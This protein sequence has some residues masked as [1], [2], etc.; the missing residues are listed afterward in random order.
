MHINQWN[1][2]KPKAASDFLKTGGPVGAR[3]TR[4][5]TKLNE[6]G[7][8]TYF[9]GCLTLTWNPDIRRLSPKPRKEVVV[10]D[11]SSGRLRVNTLVPEAV[12]ADSLEYSNHLGSVI[13]PSFHWPFQFAYGSLLAIAQARLVITSR[14]HVALPAVGLGTPVIFTLEEGKSESGLPGGS[15]GRTEG[16]TELFHLAYHN[17]KNNSWVFDQNFDWENPPPNPAPYLRQRLV[18]NLWSRIKKESMF[19]DG[20][21]MFGLFPRATNPQKEGEEE[22]LVM[23]SDGVEPLLTLRTIESVFFHHPKASVTFLR[24]SIGSTWGSLDDELETLQESGYNL[25]VVEEMPIPWLDMW[26]IHSPTILLKPVPS[27]NSA[28]LR[29]CNFL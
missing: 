21:R 7:V 20:A 10:V 22:L 14:I 26:A 4:T 12:L 29:H 15:G 11:T 2:V 18:A 24:S 19:A 16:L 25:E 8:P 3:D 17:K 9:S 1:L 5:L 23:E 27:E 28:K 6:M 13:R